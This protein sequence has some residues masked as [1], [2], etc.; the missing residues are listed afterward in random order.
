M[1]VGGIHLVTLASQK[2]CIDHTGLEL[3]EIDPPT[4][5]SQVVAP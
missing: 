5:A 3:T 1:G 2:P 4:S